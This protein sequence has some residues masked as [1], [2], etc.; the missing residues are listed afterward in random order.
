MSSLCQLHVEKNSHLQIT[1]D[2]DFSS[3]EKNKAAYEQQARESIAKSFN[4]DPSDVQIAKVTR[5]SVKF[6]FI[7]SNINRH[8]EK[9]GKMLEDPEEMKQEIETHFNK[10]LMVAK[11]NT[12]KT[13]KLSLNDF[14]TDED[15]SFS[16]EVFNNHAGGETYEQPPKG[17]F[18]K[19]LQVGPRT[20]KWIG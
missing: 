16:G 5:G 20:Q 13:F 7:V 18:G 15:R 1:V 19:A 8:N 3:Y 14:N 12:Y 4:V 6:D 11:L 10:P 9:T 17:W 2:D